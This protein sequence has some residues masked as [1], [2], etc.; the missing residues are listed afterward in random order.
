MK[1]FPE[2]IQ[3]NVVELYK[4]GRSYREITKRTGVSQRPIQRFLLNSGC[5]PR[6]VTRYSYNESAFANLN[7]ETD[8]Y[9]LGFLYADGSVS[10]SRN[11]VEINLAKKDYDHLT[12]FRDWVAP[13]SVVK[14]F[15][16]LGAKKNAPMVKL[17]IFN[18]VI[19]NR[20]IKIGCTPRKTFTLKFPPIN[21]DF[22]HHFI[23]GY[24]DGDGSIG[25]YPTKY[26]CQYSFS[27]NST[28]SFLT[29]IAKVFKEHGFAYGIR[30][31]SS[32]FRLY[33]GG[34]ENVRAIGNFL[35]NGATVFLSRK[36]ERFDSI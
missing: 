14:V 11:V 28:K 23:R 24:F 13:N 7:N 3:Q 5:V 15:R 29:Q 17:S 31:H 19:K 30:N 12:K 34:K 20:L 35:Y 22:T 10:A 4:R 32:I 21:S 9:W 1:I 6:S 33:S 8:A 16:S 36:K 27:L 25:I 26:S 2:H 18:D